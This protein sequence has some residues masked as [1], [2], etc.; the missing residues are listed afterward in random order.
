MLPN[1]YRL[2]SVSSST[3]CVWLRDLQMSKSSGTSAKHNG[4]MQLSAD[5]RKVVLFVIFV[6]SADRNGKPIKDQTEWEEEALRV[7][8]K[9]FGGA[10]A[11]PPAKGA[12]LNT[13]TN[14]LIIEHPILVHA[15]ASDD[16]ALCPNALSDIKDYCTRLGRKTSQGEVVLLIDSVLHSWKFE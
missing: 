6:P 12:W 1:V 8:S 10:T 13:Q 15:Y 11:M 14:Q 3:V 7:C 4:Q 16:K 5:N 2:T 9:H